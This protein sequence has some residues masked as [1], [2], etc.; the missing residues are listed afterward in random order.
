MKRVLSILLCLAFFQIISATAGPDSADPLASGF[1][2]PPATAKPLIWW[3]WMNGNV[4]KAGITADLEAMKRVGIGG[5]TVFNISE[6]IPAGPVKFNSPEWHEMFKFAVQEANRLDLKLGLHNCAG[7]SSSGGP[8][9]TP[10]HAMQHVTISETKITG[11]Q[12]F[13]GTLPQPPTKLDYYRDIAVLAFPTPDGESGSMKQLAPKI[14]ASAPNLPGTFG[15]PI[16]LPINKMPQFIQL[17]FARPLATRSAVLRFSQGSGRVEGVLQIS[18]DGTNFRDVRSFTTAGR[19]TR[20][21]SLALGA[22]TVSARYFRILFT[23]ISTRTKELN[24]T[25]IDLSPRL[26]IENVDAKDGDSGAFVSSSADGEPAAAGLLV[27]RDDMVDLTSR[28]DADGHLEWDAP[29]GDWTILR[30]GYTPIGVDNHP[31]PVEGTG[32]E[33]DKFSPAALDAHWAGFVQKALD[34]AGPLAGRGK[35]LDNVLIDSYEVGGQN[36]SDDFRAEFKRLRGY[37]PVPYLPAFT[38]RVVDSPE[39]SERFLWD[40]RRTIAD[41]FAEKYYGHFTE[42]CHAHDLESSFEPYTGPYESLQAGAS[43]DLPMGE[44]WVGGS[45]L[46]PS[47]KLASSI[48]HIY[49][50]RIIGTES[51]TAAPGAHGRWLDD[52]YALKA[53]GDQV[54]CTGINRLTFHRYAMQPWTNRWPGMTMGQWGTHFDRTCTWWDQGRAWI[55]YLTRCQFMLQ[56]GQFVADAAYFDGENAPSEMPDLDPALPPGHDFDAVSAL[57][58]ESATV[59]NGELV[60]ES[61]MRYRALILPASVR[62]M[63][64]QLLKKIHTLVA[65]GLNL[66]GAPPESSPSLEDY[67][68]CD[69]EVKSLTRDLWGNCDGKNVTEHSYGKGMVFWGQPLTQV[70]AGLNV[71][72][73]FEFSATNHSDLAYVHRHDGDADIYFVSNQRNHFDE[74]ACT[75]RVSGKVPELWHA[76]T[77]VIEPAPVWREENGRTMVPLQFNPAGSVFVVFRKAAD[78]DHAVAASVQGFLAP[79]NPVKPSKLIIHR[80]IYG[81]IQTKPAWMDVTAR[82][83]A[84]AAAHKLEI[85]ANNELA[86]DDPAPNIV[87][88]LRVEFVLNGRHQTNLVAENE[89]LTLA[90]GT[91]IVSAT[92][93]YLPAASSAASQTVDLTRKLSR[94]VHDGSLNVVADNGLAGTDPVF[95]IPKELRVDYSLDGVRRSATVAENGTLTLGNITAVG[96]PPVMDLRADAAGNVVVEAAAPGKVELTT[97]AGKTLTAVVKH[98]PPAVEISGPWNLSFPPNW[99]APAEVTLPKLESWTDS[100]DQGVKYFSGTATYTREIEVPDAMLAAGHSLWLDLGRVKN[101]AEVS[102]NGKSLGILWKPPFRVDITGA[103]QPGKNQLEVKVTNLW[104]NRLIG[105]EQLPDDREWVGKRLKDWPQWLLDGKPSPTGRFT[106]TTWHHWTKD[107]ALL[108]SGLLGPVRLVSYVTAEAR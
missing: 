66:V 16:T 57:V 63:T 49:G 27:N 81:A 78:G 31:G 84:L 73:D 10:E 89:T 101:L 45:T 53:L 68:Q 52:P 43:A 65:D 79:K 59:E 41:L 87:K 3:H 103:A 26:R 55:Q 61:G 14:T 13:T 67:P 86:G 35:T 33:C 6:G 98:V 69:T 72:P 19:P 38:G 97:S 82:I 36:W 77:G 54:Y 47:V 70:F 18:D 48:G 28:M 83:K 20:P 56:Q 30:I 91:E 40:V 23:H 60:L 4:T 99:G 11:G 22:K 85:V 21:L 37:D 50:R 94:L 51:F 46:D 42:L 108:E 8:W 12:K 88:Q 7:W 62:T 93:G 2:S 9:N 75:F 25:G 80:A 104:P 71:P 96:E 32:L 64:P 44:F 39:V 90:P 5:A 76:D 24:V 102:L 106:F 100:A 107:D 92:Y 1:A 105:D 17:E 29:A 15:S 58:L 34:D 74:A 95:G